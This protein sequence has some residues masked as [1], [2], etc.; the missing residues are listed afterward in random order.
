MPR[1]ISAKIQLLFRTLFARLEY[2]F[3]KA[4]EMLSE[5]N[6]LYLSSVAIAIS[7]SLAV[8]FLKTFAHKVFI[9]ANLLN[10][11]LKLPYPNSMLPIIGLILTV[12]VIKR[13]LGGSI[14]K[15]SAKILHSIAKK[16]GIVPRKQMYA[17]IMTSSLTVGLGG[18]AGLESPIVITGAAFGSNY[19]QKYSLSKNNRILLLA[20]GVAAGIG[21]AFNAPIAGVLFTIEVILA[22]ISISAFIPIMISAATGALVSKIVISGEVILSFQKVQ[23]FNFSNTFFYILLG[24]LAGL[25]SV[26]HARTF[27]K[28]EHFFNHF[29]ERIYAKAIFGALILAVLI[30]FF[31]TLFGEGYESIKILST[32]HPE[33]LLEN[34]LLECVKNEKWVLILFIGVIVFIKSIATGITLGSGGNGGNF[35]PSL[36]V[37]SYLGFVVAK[38]INILGISQLPVTNF[39]IV[40]MAGILSG[41]F[42]APLTAIFLIGEITGGYDLMIPLM[43]VSSVSYAVSKRFEEHSMDVKMLANSGDVFTSNKD[44][45]VLQSIEVQKLINI[46]A[47]TLSPEDLLDKIIEIISDSKQTIFPVLNKEQKVIGIVYYDL[48]K[49]ILFNSFQVKFTK[50][51]EIMSS[52]FLV[53]DINE[54]IDEIMNKL[55]SKEIE[56]IVVLKNNTFYGILDKIKILENYR[57]TFKNLLIN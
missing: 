6:F 35:A 43:I 36:F 56:S 25:V 50:V 27:R 46:K 24:V 26:Y 29:S 23:A 51:Q 4:K 1:R 8:I 3:F 45:N 41:L 47:E 2:F 18:S 13:F 42:H 9:W 39:T 55:D 19:A 53:I 57:L 33:I 11:Y 21:A 32:S 48:V 12:F 16:G 28:I 14:E 44:K 7:V 10:K 15:G 40:G 49:K 54:D 22:D 52:D 31:P 37:G 38:T 30:F 34:T 17:Q 5:R 20:C